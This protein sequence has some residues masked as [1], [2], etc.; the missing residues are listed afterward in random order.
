MIKEYEETVRLERKK[1]ET[2]EKAK[3]NLNITLNT[4]C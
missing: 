2:V 4:Y 3:D 1:S